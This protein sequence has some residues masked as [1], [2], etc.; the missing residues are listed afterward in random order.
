[1]DVNISQKG[2]TKLCQGG[3][4]V[5]PR[6]LHKSISKQISPYQHAPKLEARIKIFNIIELK[7]IPEQNK[8]VFSIFKHTKE[9]TTYAT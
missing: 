8:L 4:S 1:M 6:I 9:P 5:F 7:R 2:F 3:L